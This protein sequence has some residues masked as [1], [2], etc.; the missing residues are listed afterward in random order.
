M[1]RDFQPAERF[2]G[3]RSDQQIRRG[4]HRLTTQLDSV[5]T[6]DI[7]ARTAEAKPF[8]PTKTANDTLAYVV[9]SRRRASE[10]QSRRA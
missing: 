1:E 5:I 4:A 2:F 9:R 7:Q 6:D 10:P 8:R 3:L